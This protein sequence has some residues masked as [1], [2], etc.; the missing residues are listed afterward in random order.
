MVVQYKNYG[1]S[2][3]TVK[4]SQHTMSVSYSIRIP[5]WFLHYFGS[6]F[7]QIFM[8]TICCYSG[9]DMLKRI[10]DQVRIITIDMKLTKTS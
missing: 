10:S 1:K 7:I 3:I 4:H 2:S 6:E 8:T 9:N 5:N